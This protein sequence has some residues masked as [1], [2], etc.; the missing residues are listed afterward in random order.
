[1]QKMIDAVIAAFEKAEIE[2]TKSANVFDREYSEPF[3]V[4]YLHTP[5]IPTHIFEIV[6]QGEIGISRHWEIS[7]RVY[8]GFF[9]ID[10]Y[11]SKELGNR[12]KERFKNETR[13]PKSRAVID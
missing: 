8:D 9:D 4:V 2:I 1:M 5:K 12:Y 13:Q 11:T 10:F 7:R 3:G 6:S